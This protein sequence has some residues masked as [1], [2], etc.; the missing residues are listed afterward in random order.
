[1]LLLQAARGPKDKDVPECFAESRPKK[2]R[3]TE[4]MLIIIEEMMGWHHADRSTFSVHI[5]TVGITG[6][7][8]I[9]ATYLSLIEINGFMFPGS[10]FNLFLPNMHFVFE[11]GGEASE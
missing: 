9:S 11:T 10:L 3:I 7:E 6:E 5:K 2:Q 4:K 8:W 1:M